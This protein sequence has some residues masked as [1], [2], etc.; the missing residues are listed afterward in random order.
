MM[1]KTCEVCRKH[2]S[3]FKTKY[4]DE[5]LK[6]QSLREQIREELR[7]KERDNKT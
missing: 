1:T 4:C 6:R 3:L 2:I 5:C 7:N